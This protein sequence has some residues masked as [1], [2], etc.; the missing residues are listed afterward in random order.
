MLAEI[1]PCELCKFPVHVIVKKKS[2]THVASVN[3]QTGLSTRRGRYIYFRL[4][5]N[6]VIAHDQRH[7][8]A[9]VEQIPYLPLL[10]RSQLS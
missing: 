9:E 4:L 10:L 5:T 3:T 6:R 8:A 1:V 7:F 2:V